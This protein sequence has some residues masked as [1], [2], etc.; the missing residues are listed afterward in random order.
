VQASCCV[1][2]ES[3][4]GRRIGRWLDVEVAYRRPFVQMA[5]VAWRAART[6]MAVFVNRTEWG[7][8]GPLSAFSEADRRGCILY[9]RGAVVARKRVR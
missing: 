1:L 6:M 9:R 8:V 3:P 7:G 2:M 5:S 4:R